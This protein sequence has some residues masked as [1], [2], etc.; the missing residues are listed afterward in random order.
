MTQTQT[1][2]TKWSA[3]PRDFKTVVNGVRMVLVW[4]NELGTVLVPW[5]GR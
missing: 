2:R 3:I 1:P 4:D 5:T